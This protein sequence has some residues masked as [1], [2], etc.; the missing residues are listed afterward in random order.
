MYILCVHVCIR[1]LK[2]KGQ[3]EDANHS[4][5]HVGMKIALPAIYAAFKN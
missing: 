2:E 3:E 5:H 1:Y 4:V